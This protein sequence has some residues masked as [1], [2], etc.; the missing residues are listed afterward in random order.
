M[1]SYW[2]TV[3][4]AVGSDTLRKKNTRVPCGVANEIPRG[5]KNEIQNE[6][7]R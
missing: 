6:L 5:I 3:Y 7:K 1:Q 2:P 4:K